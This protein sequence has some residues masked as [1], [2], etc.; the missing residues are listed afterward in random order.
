M[1]EH[2]DAGTGG[3]GEA[4]G[5][6]CI[7]VVEDDP[8]LRK[9]VVRILQTWG[10]GIVEAPDGLAAV[11]AADERRAELGLVLLD[12]MLP[13]LNGIEVA[14]RVRSDQ[15]ELPIVACSA[16]LTEEVVANL[17][18]L[19]VERIISKP[20]SADELRAAINLAGPAGPI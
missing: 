10:Y 20:F 16:A 14:R 8:L 6:G 5:R 13:L 7:L 2:R 11:R 15:P 3:S 9:V 19:G 4:E 1:S 17:V 12:I 18:D